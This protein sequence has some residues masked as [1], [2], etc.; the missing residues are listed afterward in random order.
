MSEPIR[1][2]WWEATSRHEVFLRRFHEAGA[3]ARCPVTGAYHNAMVSQGVVEDVEAFPRPGPIDPRWP[4]ACACGY[5]FPDTASRQ[6]FP[7]RMYREAATGR[8]LPQQRLPLGAMYDATWLHEAT[9]GGK[10]WVGPDGMSLMVVLPGDA[11]PSWT[12]IHFPCDG[13]SSPDREAGRAGPWWTRTG[14]PRA[15]ETLHVTPSIFLDAPRGWHGWLRAGHLV[16]A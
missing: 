8:E 13:P 15:P 3:D 5:A 9:T 1:C 2:T 10:P 16:Q 12:G 7:E 6:V 4:S 11:G 14:D